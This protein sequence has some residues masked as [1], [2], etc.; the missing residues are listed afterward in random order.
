MII[1]VAGVQAIKQVRPP[2]EQIGL[3]ERQNGEALVLPVPRLMSPGVV[4]AGE[5]V[6]LLTPWKRINLAEEV[7]NGAVV[8]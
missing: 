7:G 1:G 8:H 6:L 4:D 3:L 2:M 5:T